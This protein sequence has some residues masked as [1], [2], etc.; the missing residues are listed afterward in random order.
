MVPNRWEKHYSELK[1]MKVEIE[2]LKK[3]L[4]HRVVF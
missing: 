2:N 1:L 4:F 3:Y